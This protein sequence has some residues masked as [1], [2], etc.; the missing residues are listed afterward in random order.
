MGIINGLVDSEAASMWHWPSKIPP[1][2]IT[3]Q[4]E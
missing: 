1:G 3:R 2:S 4:G